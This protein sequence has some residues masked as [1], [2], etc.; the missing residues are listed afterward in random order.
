MNRR[1]FLGLITS[2]A[3]VGCNIQCN[4]PEFRT[5]N[6]DDSYSKIDIIGRNDIGNYYQSYTPT[7][8]LY[9][10]YKN[11]IITK[12]TLFKALFESSCKQKIIEISLGPKELQERVENNKTLEELGLLDKFYIDIKLNGE[13]INYKLSRLKELLDQF[14]EIES[15]GVKLKLRVIGYNMKILEID[16]GYM[17][18]YLTP[19]GQELAQKYNDNSYYTTF[20]NNNPPIV[21]VEQINIK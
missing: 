17:F 14:I 12:F 16:Q 5:K 13:N 6:V 18:N 9:I 1:E 21:V 15:A 4:D 19:N 11:N 2:I 20:R 10:E 7:Y 8:D 3:V